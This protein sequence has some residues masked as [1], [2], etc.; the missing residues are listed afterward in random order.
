MWSRHEY[1]CSRGE[2]TV[3]KSLQ[4]VGPRETGRHGFP[5][6]IVV[7]LVIIRQPT[8]VLRL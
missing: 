2:I 5:L 4:P 3:A 6:L 8:R 1:G 7:F